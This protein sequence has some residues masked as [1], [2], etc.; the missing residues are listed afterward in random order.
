MPQSNLIETSLAL[1][2]D[3][4][5][6]ITPLV[7]D[8]LFASY[9]EMRAEFWRDRSGAI[10]GEMLSRVFETILDLAGPR[11]YADQMIECEIVTHDAYGIPRSV[12]TTF[13]R[14]VADTVAAA[15][16]A[17]FTPAMAAAWAALLADVDAI[18]ARAPGA[19]TPE[20]LIDPS[21]I[22]PDRT[23]Q[24]VLPHQ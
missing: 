15:A 4:A 18:V 8:R 23:G 10:R 2:A 21:T 22:L 19:D 14:A 12:F 7:Y 17:D 1:A 24:P 3:R 6:D 9:P 16:G 11:A 5:G 20:R 13:F